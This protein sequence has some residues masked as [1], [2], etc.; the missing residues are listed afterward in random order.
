MTHVGDSIGWYSPSFFEENVSRPTSFWIEY[1]SHI[2]HSKKFLSR[3]RVTRFRNVYTVEYI[4]ILE[5][6]NKNARMIDDECWGIESTWFHDDILFPPSKKTSRDQ[7]TSNL[8]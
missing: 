4:W 5:L 6:D 7:P 3:R 1:K 2:L 8:L